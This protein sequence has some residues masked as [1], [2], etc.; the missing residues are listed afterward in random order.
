[1]V[2]NNI[3]SSAFVY[4]CMSTFFDKMCNGTI[5]ILIQKLHDGQSAKTFYQDIMSFTC[6][7][8][9]IPIILLVLSM[10]STDKKEKTASPTS[11]DASEKPRLFHKIQS[12]Q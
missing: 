8:S 11:D 1:M 9:S 7:G 12:G 2:E 10:W 5:I 3:D 4:G 6:G